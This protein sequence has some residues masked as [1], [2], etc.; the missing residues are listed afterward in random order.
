VGLVRFGPIMTKPHSGEERETTKP[1]SSR[2][3]R[4]EELEARAERL[5]RM[6]DN[7]VD[8][9]YARSLRQRAAACRALAAELRVFES[10]S[11]YR[12][13]HDRPDRQASGAHAG[14]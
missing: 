6:A 8:R 4:A 12:L 13:I 2:M 11:A 9:S 1:R 10:D 14:D 7:T 3:I 5:V